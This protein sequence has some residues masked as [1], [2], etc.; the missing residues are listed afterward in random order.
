MCLTLEVANLGKTYDAG[1]EPVRALAGVSLRI[2]QGEFVA[3]MGASGSGKSTLLHLVA[4]LDKPTTGSVVVEDQD[5]S[6]MSDRQRTLFRRRRLG[7]V[8]QAYNLLP[9]LTALENVT[10]PAL[11]DGTDGSL[12]DKKGRQLLRLVNL[13]HRAGHRPDALSGGEQQRVAIA[14]A[15][16]NDP[17]VVL[18]DEPTGNLDTQHAESLWELLIRLR[19]DESRTIIAVTHEP[20]GATYADRVVMLKDGLIVGEIEP[21]GEGHASFVA[22]RYTELVG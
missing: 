9:T 4:G 18:A 22:A 2:Q 11:I 8:F 19:R 3:I 5:I 6:R 10:L 13:E 14:R 1:G 16:M 7:V 21:G 20:T 15:L 17:A 12:A